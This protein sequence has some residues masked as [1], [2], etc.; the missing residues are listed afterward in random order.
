MKSFASIATAVA[1]TL[2]AASVSAATILG[3]SFGTGQ[4][5]VDAPTGIT[6]T[7]NPAGDRRFT[8]TNKEGV[9]GVGISKGRTGDEIDTDEILRAS[10]ATGSSFVLG[11]LV[12]GLLYDGPE[13]GDVEE[14]AQITGF[15]LG[16]GQATYTLMADFVSPGAGRTFV[17]TGPGTVTNLQAANTANGNGDRGAV[18]DWSNPFGSRALTGFELTALANT[19]PCTNGG[20]CGNQSDFILV[21]ASTVPEPGSL[22]LLGLGLAGAAWVRRRRSR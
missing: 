13:F 1:L 4:T 5:Y 22:A 3:T 16:G 18:W 11:G 21:S 12:L 14:I 20:G 2:S 6:F 10:A 15:F 7:A 8:Q 9:R 17:L 19:A